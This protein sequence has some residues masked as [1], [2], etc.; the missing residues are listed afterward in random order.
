VD[1]FE[2]FLV[3]FVRVDG[4]G[5]CRCAYC[6]IFFL[7]LLRV[8]FCSV[9]LLI[10]AFVKARRKIGSRRVRLAISL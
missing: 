4:R 7:A 6:S 2:I 9:D 8:R 1:G 10:Y 5:C 3:R